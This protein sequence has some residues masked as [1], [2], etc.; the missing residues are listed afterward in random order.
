VRI[1]ADVQ[2]KHAAH[3][4]TADLSLA[5]LAEGNAFSGAD[6]LVVTGS[7]TG[8]PTSIDDVRSARA[9]ELPVL[10][11]SGVTPDNARELSTVAS[12]LIVGSFLKRDGHWKNEVELE[13]VRSIARAMKP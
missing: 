9:A 3:A 12:G 4:L 2:K 11:G 13:R 1:W 10:V 8:K 7:S 6:A 5:D